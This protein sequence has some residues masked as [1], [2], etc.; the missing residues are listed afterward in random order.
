MYDNDDE[1]VKNGDYFIQDSNDYPKYNY[2]AKV[3]DDM[4]DDE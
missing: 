2:D 4:V 1:V 3:N